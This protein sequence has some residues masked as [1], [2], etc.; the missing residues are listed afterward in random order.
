VKVGENDVIDLRILMLFRVVVITTVFSKICGESV[1]E[2]LK[3]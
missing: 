1:G 2:V 3:L